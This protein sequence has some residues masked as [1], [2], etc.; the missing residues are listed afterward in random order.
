MMT[1]GIYVE[2]YGDRKHIPSQEAKSASGEHER[3]ESKVRKL[4]PRSEN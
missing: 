3:C 2:F 4:R 1:L